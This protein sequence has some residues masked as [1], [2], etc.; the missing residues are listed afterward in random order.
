MIIHGLN[1]IQC[2]YPWIAV[3]FEPAYYLNPEKFNS[4]VVL[5]KLLK[6]K[7]HTVY[8]SNQNR[9]AACFEKFCYL[10]F[11]FLIIMNIGASLAQDALK[12]YTG[13][14]N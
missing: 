11:F 3:S 5:T 4:L 8:V 9:V 6:T 12:L 10:R 14:Q 2:D 7:M 13:T 1:S